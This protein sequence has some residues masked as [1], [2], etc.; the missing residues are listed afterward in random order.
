MYW[1]YDIP[2]WLLGL[3]TVS[4]FVL[5][6]I[7]GLIVSRGWAGRTFRLS[8][9]TNE[10][11]NGFFAGVGVMYSLLLGLVA[12]AVWQ[13][14]DSSN[15]LASKEAAAIVALYRDVSAFP[16]EVRSKLQNHLA[17][18]LHYVID[19]EF[20]AHQR[21]ETPGEGTLILSGFQGLLTSYQPA[22]VNQEVILAEALTAFNK[23]IEA[24]RLR[25]DAVNTGIPSVFWTVIMVGAVLS[26]VLT[27]T[28]HLPTLKTHLLLT[29]IYSILNPCSYTALGGSRWRSENF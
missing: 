11:V 22:T 6:S 21:G 19:S 26:I 25:V 4:T 5:V 7:L 3:F 18:Y 2:T 27:Y 13:N 28:F 9:E 8:D 20:P 17:K 1:I 14:F 12:V 16:V 10:A 24:R 23:V 29:G 15:A